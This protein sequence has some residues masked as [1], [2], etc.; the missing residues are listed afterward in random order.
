MEFTSSSSTKGE[1]SSSSAMKDK[2]KCSLAK[3]STKGSLSR[4]DSP[5][6]SKVIT[7]EEEN[8]IHKPGM[9]M[10]LYTSKQGKKIPNAREIW[11]PVVL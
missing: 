1:S 7:H 8:Q 11:W 9:Q 2:K 5:S 6:N 3:T 10:V 4:F